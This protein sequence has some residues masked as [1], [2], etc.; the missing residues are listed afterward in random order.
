MT[1]IPSRKYQGTIVDRAEFRAQEAWIAGD[2]HLH[3]LLTGLVD[4]LE[5]AWHREEEKGPCG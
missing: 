1:A 4:E 5:A 2:M 3:D